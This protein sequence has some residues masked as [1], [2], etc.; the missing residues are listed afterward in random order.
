M[1]RSI[2]AVAGVLVVWIIVASLLDRVLRLLIAGYA[3]AEPSMHFTLDMMLA[4]LTIGALTSLCAGAAAALLAPRRKPVP[5]VAGAI[6]LA[7]FLPAH[8]R[9]WE[10]FPVWYHLTFLVTIVPLFVAGAALARARGLANAQP[11]TADD[12]PR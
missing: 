5:W 3:A 10:L 7:L 1:K 11:S 12:G 9:L 6:V 8:V 2:L 4:R